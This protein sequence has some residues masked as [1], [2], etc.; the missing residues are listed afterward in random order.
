MVRT[1]TQGAAHWLVECKSTRADLVHGSRRELNLSKAA[2]TEVITAEEEDENV[3][4]PCPDRE[5]SVAAYLDGF[6]ELAAAILCR[7]N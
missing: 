3:G 5:V 4:Q 6:S 7:V 2:V 1:V